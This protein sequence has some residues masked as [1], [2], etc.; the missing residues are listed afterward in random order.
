MKMSPKSCSCNSC[1]LGKKSH[2]GKLTIKKAERSYR[3][4][5]KVMLNKGFD[6]LGAAPFGKYTD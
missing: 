3:H 1:K 4:N 6:N 5:S 2:G